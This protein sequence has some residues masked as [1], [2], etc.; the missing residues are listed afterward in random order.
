MLYSYD[1]IKYSFYL[2]VAVYYVIINMV[3]VFL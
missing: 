1:I 3:I 2:K